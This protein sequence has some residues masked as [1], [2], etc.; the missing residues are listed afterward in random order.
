MSALGAGSEKLRGVLLAASV[1]AGLIGL[2]A[3]A[4]LAAVSFSL[5]GAYRSLTEALPAWQAGV[6]VAGFALVLACAALLWARRRLKAGRR[7][8]APDC[9]DTGNEVAD[10]AR[11]RGV[12]SVSAARMNEAIALAQ[13][14]SDAKPGAVDVAAAGFVAGLLAALG[15]DEGAGH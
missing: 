8:N 3:F 1:S 9:G 5:I 12:P 11:D 6:A 2:A 7:V 13:R 14:L 15:S 10:D 4:V